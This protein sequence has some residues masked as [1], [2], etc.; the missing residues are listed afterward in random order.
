[1][2]ITILTIVAA[3]LLFGCGDSATE[4]NGALEGSA[5]CGR[6]TQGLVLGEAT[7][8]TIVT[9]DGRTRDYQRYIPSDYDPSKP[10]R[11]IIDSHGL[12]SSAMQERNLSGYLER[13]ESDGAIVLW[14][15]ALGTPAMWQLRPGDSPDDI[16]LVSQLLDETEARLCVDSSRIYASG[17]SMGGLFSSALACS[18]NE[19]IAAIAPVAGTAYPGDPCDGGRLVPIRAFHGDADFIVSFAGVEENVQRWATHHGCDPVPTDT[20]VGADVIHRVY[21]GCGAKLELYIVEGGGHN[22]PGNQA[23]IDALP[24]LEDRIRV[25]LGHITTEIDAT[26][27]AWDFFDEHRLP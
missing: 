13:A 9:G 19:R 12:G 22:W 16:A 15:D 21:P 27:L 25:I 8:E 11:V 4:S 3:A 26:A 18:L 7:H 14:G 5:G 2:R 23:L 10:L 1:M 17:M 6:G 20:R 24:G